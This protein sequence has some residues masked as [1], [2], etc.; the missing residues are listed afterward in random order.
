[1]GEEIQKTKSQSIVEATIY[2]TS[3]TL[4]YAVDVSKETSKETVKVER[5]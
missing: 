4:K 1:M 5:G 3:L 2:P